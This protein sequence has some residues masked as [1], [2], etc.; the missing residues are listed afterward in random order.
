MKRKVPTA[1]QVREAQRTTGIAMTAALG[2]WFAPFVSGLAC[3]EIERRLVIELLDTLGQDGAASDTLFWVHR[4]RMLAFNVATYAPWVGTSLQV[5]EVYS[6]GQ[7]VIACA[8]DRTLQSLT[9]EPAV[10]KRWEL[11]EEDI[12]SGER[13]AKSYEEFT[14]ETFPA[15]IRKPFIGAVD[16]AAKTYTTAARIPGL[17]F[18]QEKAGE[19]MRRSIRWARGLLPKR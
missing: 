5:L 3:N 7:F 14:G 6:M 16:A 12:L 2:A 18:V 8:R 11:I 17:Q 9:D 1:S 15:A 13:V 19:G 4:K 10:Q